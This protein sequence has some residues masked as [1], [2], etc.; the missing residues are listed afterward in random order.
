ML[1]Q[2]SWRDLA[3]VNSDTRQTACTNGS[4]MAGHIHCLASF[5]ML[6]PVFL[7]TKVAKKKLMTTKKQIDFNVFTTFVLK[8]MLKSGHCFF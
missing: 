2:E 7:K 4:L 3:T 8:K 1:A 5:R 6:Y